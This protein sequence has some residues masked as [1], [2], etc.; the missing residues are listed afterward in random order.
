M[1]LISV[2]LR[3]RTA[4]FSSSDSEDDVLEEDHNHDVSPDTPSATD[5]MVESS[6]IG[7]QEEIETE[8]DR[9]MKTTKKKKKKALLEEEE[10]VHGENAF[11]GSTLDPLHPSNLNTEVL[12]SSKLYNK[13]IE[14]AKT[15]EEKEQ[16]D[17]ANKSGAAKKNFGDRRVKGCPPEVRQQYRELLDAGWVLLL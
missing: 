2:R 1:S 3:S 6:M 9:V 10:M 8:P 11:L 13:V 16:E 15:I 7:D 14:D 12:E 4:M 5:D 17:L